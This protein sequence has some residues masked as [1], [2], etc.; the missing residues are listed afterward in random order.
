MVY[1]AAARDLGGTGS[2]RAAGARALQVPAETPAQFG[3]LRR[4]WQ[5]PS[6]V[7]PAARAQARESRD[8]TLYLT[9]RAS[10]CPA[11]APGAVVVLASG[12]CLHVA[13]RYSAR[14]DAAWCWANVRCGCGAA[15]C[16]SVAVTTAE[17]AVDASVNA[18]RARPRPGPCFQRK[19][20]MPAVS[21][22]TRPLQCASRC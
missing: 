22:T 18:V 13:A 20:C 21:R 11:A 1:E 12:H 6:P 17:G 4:C 14:C 9:P 7:A 19:P 10:G 2:P 3:G 15:R 16:T 8:E 5:E